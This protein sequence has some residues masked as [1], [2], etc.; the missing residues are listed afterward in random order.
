MR[1][2]TMFA[3]VAVRYRLALTCCLML[4]GGVCLAQPATPPV[5][6]HLAKPDGLPTIVDPATALLA[7]A[8]RRLGIGLEIT[9]RPHARA[10]A[11][12]NAG[13]FD[14][15]LVRMAGLESRAPDLRRVPNSLFYLQHAVYATHPISVDVT[16]WHALRVSGLRVGT[17]LGAA[18]AEQELEGK[19]A[20]RP[21]SYEALVQ[22]LLLGRIDVAVV[23]NG[24]IETLLKTAPDEI[25]SQ[26]TV[27]R[28]LVVFDGAPVY[29]YLHKKNAALIAPLAEQLRRM[30]ADGT[31]ARVLKPYQEFVKAP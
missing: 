29:H 10:L 5:V 23:V 4:S 21:A 19:L 26:Q 24:V 17:R 22:M 27:I 13:H 9:A 8:Y 11:E 30:Q 15:E 20:S 18:K 2:K 1:G 16:S 3:S 28:K 31:T 6:I 12:S 7:E 14:G 25:R